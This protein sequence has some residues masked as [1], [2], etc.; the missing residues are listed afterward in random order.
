MIHAEGKSVESMMLEGRMVSSIMADGK[1]IWQ[2][3]RSCFGSGYWRGNKPWI[4]KDG[5]KGK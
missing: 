1:I 4:G 2:A 3:I 5:W